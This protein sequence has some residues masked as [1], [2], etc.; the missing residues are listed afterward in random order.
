MKSINTYFNKYDRGQILIDFNTDT[1]SEFLYCYYRDRE[2]ELELDSFNNSNGYVVIANLGLWKGRSLNYQVI[3]NLTDIHFHDYTKVY[4]YHGELVIEDSH[5]DGTNIL[6]VR[7]INYNREFLEV[8]DKFYDCIYNN[9][10]KLE[11]MINYYTEKL[12]LTVL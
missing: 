3:D 5:H 2:E 11:N 10:N 8:N 4:N 7:K 1:K 6:I 12:D 9:I